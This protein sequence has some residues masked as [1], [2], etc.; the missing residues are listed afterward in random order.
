MTKDE[1]V[2][3]IR[4]WPLGWPGPPDAPIEWARE[5]WELP[6]V[7]E[8]VSYG[9]ARDVGKTGSLCRTDE[10]LG[11]FADIL[12]E[13]QVVRLYLD[14]RDKHGC[15]PREVEFRSEFLAAFA[16]HAHAIPPALTRGEIAELLGLT[17]EEAEV[18]PDLPRWRSEPPTVGDDEEIP[19]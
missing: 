3:L 6:D 14:I 10:Y 5:V 4:S 16:R 17:A 11:W 1:Y 2:A 13:E 18:Y 15:A 12:T 9:L 7:R 8:N 19:F